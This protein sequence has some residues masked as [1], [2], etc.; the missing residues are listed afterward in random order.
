MPEQVDDYFHFRNLKEHYR[1]NLKEHWRENLKEHYW[2]LQTS[3][4][5]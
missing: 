4:I 5:I 2:E 3:M 1:E